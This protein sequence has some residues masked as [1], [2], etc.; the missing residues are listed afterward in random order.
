MA[1]DWNAVK[2]EYIRGDTSCRKLADKYGVS[3][4]AVLKKCRA[5]KWTDL[6]NQKVIKATSKTVERIA[7]QEAEKAVD[8]MDIAVL[9]ARKIREGIEE[10]VYTTDAQSTRAITAALRDLRE[11]AGTKALKDLEEQQARI[12]KLR[13]EA[14]DEEE[15]HDIRVVIADDLKEFSE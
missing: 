7:S 8:I 1:V 6:R 13:K 10:G 4:S 14:R 11:I 12:E 5:E 9:L 15:S 3:S 2:A